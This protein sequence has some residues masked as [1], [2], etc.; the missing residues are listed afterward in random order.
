MLFFLHW[1]ISFCHKF[2][3]THQQWKIYFFLVRISSFFRFIVFFN[4]MAFVIT[5]FFLLVFI[6]HQSFLFFVELRKKDIVLGLFLIFIFEHSLI[7]MFSISFIFFFNWLLVLHC[8]LNKVEIHTFIW[9]LN[10][11]RESAQLLLG[12]QISG[13]NSSCVLTREE[14]YNLFVHHL[15]IL[16]INSVLKSTVV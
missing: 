2:V 16:G 15:T 8:H 9:I 10:W 11:L 5:H 4:G 12:A 14:R 13:S 7:E 6:W 1:R 3:I